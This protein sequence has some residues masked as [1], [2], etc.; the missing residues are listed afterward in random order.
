MQNS[1]CLQGRILAVLL[2][3]VGKRKMLQMVGEVVGIVVEVETG[4]G[5]GCGG[6]F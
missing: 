3:E 5:E 2:A 6:G 1:E 4:S